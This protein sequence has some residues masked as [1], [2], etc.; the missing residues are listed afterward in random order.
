MRMSSITCT[1]PDELV[2]PTFT[3]FCLLPPLLL[4]KQELPATPALTVRALASPTNRTLLAVGLWLIAGITVTMTSVVCKFKLRSDLTMIS[5]GMGSSNVL[6]NHSILS[7][8]VDGLTTDAY[9]RAGCTCKFLHQFGAL[10]QLAL[11]LRL[12]LLRETSLVVFLLMI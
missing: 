8:W 11:A 4:I 1:I 9:P 7:C 6:L 2:G 3:P 12:F 5:V 10:G